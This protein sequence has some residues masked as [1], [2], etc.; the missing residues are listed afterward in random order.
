MVFHNSG[1]DLSNQD[2]HAVI[3]VN[4]QEIF[5]ARA[6]VMLGHALN[7]QAPI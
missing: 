4:P 7:V 2:H 5:P 1:M 6:R 3:K